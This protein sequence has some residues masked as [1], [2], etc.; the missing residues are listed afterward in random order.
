MSD[1]ANYAKQELLRDGSSVEIRA[2]RPTD[3]GDMLAALAQISAQ[4]LQRRFFAMKRHFSD[5]ERAFFM[6]VDFRNHVALVV[7]AGDAGRQTIVGGGRYIVV[8]SGQAE[9]AF[10]VI[11]AW[12]GRGIG[13]LLMRHLVEIARDAGLHELTAEVLPENAQMLS[14]FGKFGFK[15]AARRDPQTVHLALTL[16]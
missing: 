7:V 12:Q 2:L 15:P 1:P 9:M 11:D 4:S 13:S 8:E 10:V 6:N 14:V 5:K 16:D 3:E